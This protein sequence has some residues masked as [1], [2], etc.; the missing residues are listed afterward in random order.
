MKRLGVPAT[1]RA[2]AVRSAISP[3]A[4]STRAPA[5]LIVHLKMSGSLLLNPRLPHRFGRVLIEFDNGARL[6]FADVRRFGR[7]WLVADPLAVVG[8]L[9]PEPLSPAFT[10][11]LLRQ[12]LLKRKAPIKAVLLDQSLLAGVGNMYADEALFLAR[13]HPEET[14]AQ[15]S[16]PKVRRLH[17]AIRKVLRDAIGQKGASD[18]DYFRPDGSRGSAH[19]TFNVAHRRGETCRVCGTPIERIVVRGRGTYFC[20]HCQPRTRRGDL[21]SP[22]LAAGSQ[23]GRGPS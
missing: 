21:R 1:S 15:L 12:R 19:H 22:A 11:E 6:L 14:A 2:S 16:A 13:I 10:P 18:R 20:P 7:M 9:G 23:E 17:A 3:Q 4:L 5:S 8:G